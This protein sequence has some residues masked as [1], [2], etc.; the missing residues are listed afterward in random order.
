VSHS[1]NK[2]NEMH[3]ISQIYFRNRTLHVSD[4]F[5]AHHKESSTVHTAMVCVIYVM[6]T[7]C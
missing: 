7:A 5:S 3:L 6:L 4:S 2:T 1:Y